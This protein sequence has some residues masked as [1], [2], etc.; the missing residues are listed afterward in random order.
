MPTS[1]AGS[2]GFTLLELLV[3][4]A[5]MGLVAALAGPAIA[6]RL[7]DP[8]A[9]RSARL[10]K[11]LLEQARAAAPSRGAPTAVTWIPEGRSFLLVGIEP[12][13]S[14]QLP[15]GVEASFQGLTQIQQPGR[16][17]GRLAGIL[18]HPL[19][20]STG[21]SIVLREGTT[22]VHLRVDRL[23][24]AAVYEDAP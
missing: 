14:F 15:E 3:A 12:G 1:R 18:F 23:T 24:G 11:G 5:I 7:L 2:D 16:A 17:P 10:V 13:R 9:A 20:G 8:P 4:L 21:G 6:G 19:G 22:E